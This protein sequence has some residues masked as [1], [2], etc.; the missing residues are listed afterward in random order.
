MI[1]VVT[2][3]VVVRDGD[4]PDAISDEQA[5]TLVVNNTN[6][7]PVFISDQ[8]DTD[9]QQDAQFRYA[10]EGLTSMTAMSRESSLTRSASRA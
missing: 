2:V 9:I 5:F 8:Q 7:A 10:I 3:R 4:G 1:W 6:D